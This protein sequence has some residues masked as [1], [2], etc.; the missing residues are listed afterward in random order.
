ML[1][2]TDAR[3]GRLEE[4]RPPRPRRLR[5]DVATPG[6]DPGA[7]RVGVVAD[8]LRRAGE[9]HAV[10]VRLVRSGPGPDLTRD[11]SALNA[12]PAEDPLAGRADVLVLPAGGPYPPDAPLVLACGPVRGGAGLADLLADGRD[13]LAVRLALLAAVPGAPADLSPE[14]LA[15][16]DADL[17]AWRERVA[18]WAEQPSAAIEAGYRRDLLDAFDDDLDTPRALAVLRLLA[19]DDGVPP[20]GRFETAAWADR[21]LGLDLAR[22]V[23]RPRA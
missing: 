5:V 13:P 23:G 18:G 21:L 15:A 11:L 22:D 17:A 3:T 7:L 14:R 2:L 1:R 9:Q 6:A 19:D 8:L 12:R 20:G 4:V 16:A 10:S